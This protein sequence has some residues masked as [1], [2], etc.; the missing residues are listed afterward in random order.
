MGFDAGWDALLFRPLESEETTMIRELTEE[1]KPI[2][3]RMLRNAP[4]GE[5][6]AKAKAAITGLLGMGYTWI[7]LDKSS[8]VDMVFTQDFLS[9]KQHYLGNPEAVQII[10]KVLRLQF[11]M[12]DDQVTQ[13]LNDVAKEKMDTNVADAFL[14]ALV[15]VRWMDCGFPAI[16]ISPKWAAATLCTRV[17][18]DV[19]EGIKPP[20]ESFKILMP[21]E[22][23]VYWFKHGYPRHPEAES[24]VLSEICVKYNPDA[25]GWTIIIH[26]TPE[27]L[28]ALMTAKNS[29]DLLSDANLADTWD[30]NVAKLSNRLV[31]S[32]LCTFSKNHLTQI[33]REIH[34]Q[35]EREGKKRACT[36]PVVREFQLTEPVTV[37]LTEHVRSFQL[38]VYHKGKKLEVQFMV[39]GHRKRQPYGP[40]LSLRKQIWV[41]PYWRGPEDAPIAV[42][43]HVIKSPVPAVT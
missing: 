15:G 34:K 28:A 37:D 10:W 20:W 26:S 41:Q 5:K 30:N 8:I 9:S 23:I 17:T 40:G 6:K 42:R 3:E 19:L 12:S 13:R 14:R 4:D 36:H 43:P 21:K 22:P 24:N 38:G 16:K 33:N 39:A 29:A 25:G 2:V 11:G 32:V 31:V 7:E 35:Y 1:E 27:G 18:K